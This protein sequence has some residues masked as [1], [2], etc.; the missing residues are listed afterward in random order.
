[1]ASMKILHLITELAPAG[2]ERC[3]YELAT[4]M[5]PAKFDVSVAALRG[6]A[7]ADRLCEAGIHVDILGVRGKFDVGKLPKLRKLIRGLQ[8]DILHTHLF[9]ADFAGRLAAWP[10]RLGHLVHT[11]HIAEERFRPWQ[12]AFQ[13]ITDGMCDTIIAVSPSACDHHARKCRIAP[14]RY[15]VIP[16]GVDVAAYSRDEQARTRLRKE[17]NVAE[18]EFLLAFVGRCDHQKGVDTLLEA[19]RRIN[20]TGEAVKLVIAGDGPQA[21]MVRR[22]VSDDPAGKNVLYLGFSDR[23][24][25]LLSAAD[26]LAMPSRWEGFGLAAAEAM[27]ASLPLIATSASGIKDVV[28]AD[29]TALVIRPED[30]EGLAGCIRHLADDRQLADRLGKAGRKRV[31]DKFDV[32]NTV[33]AHE[34]LYLSIASVQ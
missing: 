15:V 26:A 17:W 4:R 5:D 7:F 28:V 2:A 13:R 3:V 23:V 34:A 29:E 30:A 10:M 25:Q 20:R 14:D 19:M 18:R 12:F 22:F 8:P 16:N 21:E 11:V 33:A 24:A 32:A 9:H 27:A 31:S 6:G 1:M